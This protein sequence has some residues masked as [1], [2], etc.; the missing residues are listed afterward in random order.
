MGS[1]TIRFSERP[2]GAAPWYFRFTRTLAHKGIPGSYRALKV[3]RGLGMLNKPAAIPVGPGVDVIVPP[4]QNFWDQAEIA[5]YEQ[6][7][8]DHL[9]PLVHRMNA[10]VLIDCGADIGIFSLKLYAQ[11]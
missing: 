7:L 3:M 11:A 5:A 8:F 9:A 6:D 10:P 1:T 2:T 4:S